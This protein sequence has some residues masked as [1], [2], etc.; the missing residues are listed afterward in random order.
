MMTSPDQRYEAEPTVSSDILILRAGEAAIE[1]AQITFEEVVDGSLVVS[2]EE[3]IRL[4]QSVRAGD[5]VIFKP[6]SVK[7]KELEADRKLSLLSGEL[8][9]DTG[10]RTVF[11]DNK[12]VGVTKKEYDLLT[13]L[14]QNLN[15]VLTRKSIYTQVWG[16]DYLRGNTGNTLDVH[17]KRLRAHLGR[18]RKAIV[19]KRHV[20]YL[21][22]DDY[23]E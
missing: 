16:E 17:I 14:A 19:T 18:H 4:A 3:I 12:E 15:I 11:I 13:L 22:T 9:I 21:F 6:A 2:T 23:S 8:I 1:S 20:G 10:K 7:D 5:Y